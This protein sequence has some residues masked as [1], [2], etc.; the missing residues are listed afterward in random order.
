VG[1]AICIA[2]YHARFGAW[3]T[4]AR[5]EAGYLWSIAHI[6]GPVG[7]ERLAD[8]ME[9]RTERHSEEGGGI[10][11]GGRDGV[12]RYERVDHERVSEESLREAWD[13]LRLER[14]EF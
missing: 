4:H 1:L 5:F 9:L 13:W 12:Q 3:P 11:V 8:L 6:V 10:S 2:V 14:D 7:F